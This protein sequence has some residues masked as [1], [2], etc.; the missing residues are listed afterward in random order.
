MGLSRSCWNGATS[1]LQPEETTSKQLLEF[2][3]CTINK[4]AHTKKSGKLLKALYIYIYIYIMK[5]IP[6]WPRASLSWSHQTTFQGCSTLNKT[7]LKSRLV[8]PK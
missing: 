8:K 7:T 4:S 5:I 6:T 3:V 1:G 2:N